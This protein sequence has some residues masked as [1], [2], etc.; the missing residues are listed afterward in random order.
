MTA[1]KK[2]PAKVAS[3]ADFKKK[4]AAT[5]TLPSG[6]VVEV[7]NPG[8][9]RAFLKDGIIPNSLM[10]M[11]QNALA[12]GKSTPEMSISDVEPQTIAEMMEM[13]DHI[14][15]ACMVKPRVYDVPDDPDERSDDLL[16]T[17]EIEDED[18]MF[19]FNWLTG[20]TKELEP[21]RPQP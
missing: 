18:K 10:P 13:M 15:V 16:Y 11:V 17:D 12:E 1:P 4:R 14:T 8:G 3:A 19:I 5:L 2:T 7:R 20:G 21:F 6:F 9:M